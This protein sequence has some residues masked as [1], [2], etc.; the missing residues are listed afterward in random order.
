MTQPGTAWRRVAGLVAG[1]AC[2]SVV[3]TWPLAA[4]ATTSIAGDYGD[5]VFVAW[6]MAWV[7][8]H[9]TRLAG[10]DLSAWAAMWSPPIFAPEPGALTFSDHFLAQAVLGL[11]A[12]WLSGNA[13]LTYNL[14][15]LGT[16]IL[17]ALAAHGLTRRLS[18]S[19]VAGLAA[20]LLCTFNDY[21]TY[22]ALGHLQVLSLQWWLFGLWA[23]DVFVDTRSRRALAGATVS[24]IALHLS[25]S[26]LMAYCAPFTAVFALWSLWRHG[27]LAERRA[28]AGAIGAG[29]VSVGV[30]LPIVAKYLATRAALGFVRRDA[31]LIG[32]SASPEAY[33]AALPWLLPLVLLGITGA[34]APDRRG[35]AGRRARVVL[36]T[37]AAA[38]FVLALGPIVSVGGQ[39]LTGPY[40]WLRTLVPG[41]D[42]LRV[43]HRFVAIAA[44]WLAVLGGIG[45]A[46]LSRRRLGLVAAT[47]AVGL[48]TRTAWQPPFPLDAVL[49]SAPLAAPPAYLRPTAT[50]PRIYQHVTTTPREAVF[51]ELPFGDI[52]YEIRYTFFTAGHE[53][54][55]L[56]GY[57]GVL[58]P[59]YE[60]RKS[61][62]VAPLADP[63][64]AW[65]A[66][67]PATHVVV[68]TTAYTDDSGQRLC[69]WLDGRGARRLAAADGAVLF[70]L[71]AR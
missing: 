70:A 23:L 30:V 40:Q 15:F 4:R 14:V 43:P 54:R 17:T 3:M 7:S 5:P 32:G 71:P 8:T 26:Y 57:S 47:V 28:W 24:F 27:R 36:L 42:G 65:A 20:A 66:L 56:N 34:A 37:L 51:A 18:G 49:A 61:A 44:T 29:L 38:A 46:W 67:S 50:L 1:Y 33:A 55:I 63:D 58:P 59:S 62:L 13:V 53:R 25:S 11:P 69:E 22:W 12:W 9:L 52:G 41:Y 10:G 2:V 68:H 64:A 16:M 19:D 21:R 39:Q 45:V 60:R 48:V 31:E 35:L 6:V